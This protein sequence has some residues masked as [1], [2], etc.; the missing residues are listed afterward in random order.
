MEWLVI[1]VVA[2]FIIGIGIVTRDA[3]KHAKKEH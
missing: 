3:I 2:V 1:G